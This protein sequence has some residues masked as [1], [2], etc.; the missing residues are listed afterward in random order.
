[1]PPG[2]EVIAGM[3]FFVGVGL[4]RSSADIGTAAAVDGVD[5]VDVEILG[6]SAEQIRSLGRALL[7]VA[8]QIQ[9]VQSTQ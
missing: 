4:A 8:D 6:V 2:D 5:A 9:R 1:M 3:R 7:S